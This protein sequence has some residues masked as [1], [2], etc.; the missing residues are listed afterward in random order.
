MNPL[1]YRKPHKL[2]E[3]SAYHHAV[4]EASAGTGKTYTMEH[5]VVELLLHAEVKIEE[6]LVVTFTERAT[7]EL[8]MRIRALLERIIRAYERGDAGD[9]TAVAGEPYWMI[10][11]EAG[12]KLKEALFAFDVAPIYTIHGFCQRILTEHAFQNHRLFNEEHVDADALF[13]EVF[14]E[15]LRHDFASQEDL[16]PYLAMWME[17]QTNALQT[18]RDLLARCISSRAELR[19]VFDEETLLLLLQKFDGID[20]AHFLETLQKSLKSDGVH[21]GSVKA[22]LRRVGP[23]LE[24]IDAWADHRSTAQFLAEFSECDTGY[25]YEKMHI[26][27]RGGKAARGI[28]KLLQYAVPLRAAMAQRL[29]PLIDARL[30]AKKNAEGLFSFDDMLAMVWESLERDGGALTENLRKRYRYGLIDEF[31]DTDDLQWKIFRRIFFASGRENILYLIGDP[32]QAIYSF[33][34]ADVHTYLDARQEVQSDGGM[35]VRLQENFRSTKEV[36]AAYNHIFDQ[37]SPRPFFTGRIDYAHP[38]RCGRP[39]LA[40][41]PGEGIEPAP[42]QIIQ[43]VP[44]DGQ[45][46]RAHGLRHGLARQFASEI[47]RLLDAGPTIGAGDDEPRNIL[48]RDI[49]VLTHKKKEGLLL[50]EY[51]RAEGVPYAFYKQDGLFQTPEAR[52]VYELLSAIDQPYHRPRRLRA[53]L[54]PFFGIPI[55]DL[56]HLEPLDETHPLFEKLGAWHG[57]A[58]ER[59]FEELFSRIV[60]ES[61]LIRREIF[62]KESEREL[63]NY[64]HIFEILL[65]EGNRKR[66]DLARLLARLQAFIE[67]RALPD[68]E[69]GNIQ[70]LESERNAVQIMTMHKSKGQEA[71]VVF[72]FGGFTGFP[73]SGLYTFHQQDGSRVMSIDRLTSDEQILVAREAEEEEQRLLYVTLTRARGRLYL[74]YVAKDDYAIKG[75]LRHVNARLEAIVD[76]LGRGEHTD[77][78]QLRRFLDASLSKSSGPNDAKADLLG[79]HPPEELLAESAHDDAELAGYRGRHLLV[80]SYSRLKQNAGGYRSHLP[81]DEFRSDTVPRALARLG[82]HALPGGVASGNFL[83]QVIEDIDLD[84]VVEHESLEGWLEDSEVDGHYRRLMAKFGIEDRWLSYSK[85]VIYRALRC[86]VRADFDGSPVLIDSLAACAPALF[87]LEFLYPIP[88]TFHRRLGDGAAGPVRIERGFIKGFIDFVFEHQGKI[89]FGDWKSDILEDYQPVALGKHIAS[90]YEIQAKLYSLAMVKTLGLHD[91]ATY[92]A[93]FGGFFYFFLR[94]MGREQE[95]EGVYFQRPSWDGLR[96]Y[97]EELIGDTV[98]R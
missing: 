77:L 31:Q 64:L 30:R 11:E 13:D 5:L 71:D 46:F 75:C 72:V 78:F 21:G 52:D 19:P 82:E 42:V 68:G 55:A 91:E 50:G 24:L 10:D 86:P 87:E 36:I 32:K 6:I 98:Y 67:E 58:E 48:P 45:K 56:V 16:V 35:G 3:L 40:I 7:S 60:E 61:G 62:F 14:A 90:Q 65:E 9:E 43:L 51:L 12:E 2:D 96:A 18:L 23:M 47:R 73:D 8:K 49:F 29:T 25:L 15:T 17:T 41:A 83:H 26:L 92:D 28:I 54:T 22:V 37:E 81:A 69:D 4:I 27:E 80:T 76:G 89:Y 70:R 57:L 53:W 88:E 59:R 66:L 79:W 63:T 1:R 94:G 93:H 84:L 95:D 20:F 39:E 34:G 38:V 33:R 97:E 44:A 74:P 85:E